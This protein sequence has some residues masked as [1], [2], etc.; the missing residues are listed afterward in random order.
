V[1]IEKECHTPIVRGPMFPS[2]E[3]A[4]D[5]EATITIPMHY[6]LKGL[7]PAVFSKLVGA[8]S[9]VSAIGFPVE[10]MAKL[11]LRKEILDENQKIVSLEK[12]SV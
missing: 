2:P 12:K 6:Q 5:F 8:E 7:D 4:R 11:S 9:F 1:T 10:K 3:A